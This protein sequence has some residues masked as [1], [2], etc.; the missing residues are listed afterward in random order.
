MGLPIDL[1]MPLKYIP[2]ENLKFTYTK[3]SILYQYI[4]HDSSIYN[5]QS[6]NAINIYQLINS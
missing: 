2:K 6:G 1:A 5:V 3:F 4:Y